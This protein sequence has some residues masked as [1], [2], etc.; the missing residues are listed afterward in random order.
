MAP[1]IRRARLPV[2]ASAHKGAGASPASDGTAKL[3][4]TVAPGV[5]RC[6]GATVGLCP[7]VWRSRPRLRDPP[8]PDGFALWPGLRPDRTRQRAT[9][10]TATY[11]LKGRCVIAWG[12]SPRIRRR[13]TPQSRR[14]TAAHAGTDQR[15]T[16]EDPPSPR[17]RRAGE[18]EAPR[19]RSR[20]PV[21]RRRAP[22]VP[23]S[24]QTG[25]ATGQERLPCRGPV[26]P[27]GHVADGNAPIA[28][29]THSAGETDAPESPPGGQITR[30]GRETASA[31][32]RPL[33]AHW[34]G[35][36]R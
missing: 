5:E 22:A 21:G 30:F 12:F 29:R 9:M 7:A 1:A 2:E 23:N 34:A 24:T 28:K 35:H 3:R 26:G 11:A 15:Q 8:E 6:V 25:H 18:D 16:A 10:A 17:L 31:G 33:R 4:L 36:A 27:S 14:A 13:P 32:G 19:R 20:P